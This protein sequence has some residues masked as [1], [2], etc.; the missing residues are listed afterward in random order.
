MISTGEQWIESIKYL[1]AS[2][3]YVANQSY[4]FIRT[5]RAKLGVR[6]GVHVADLDLKV[7][8]KAK[9]FGVSVKD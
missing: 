1:H 5:Q 2:C 7:S 8:G 9:I 4:N 6:V 3:L